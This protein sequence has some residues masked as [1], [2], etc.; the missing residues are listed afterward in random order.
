MSSFCQGLS[1]LV[2]RFCSPVATQRGPQH[3]PALGEGDRVVVERGRPDRGDPREH[4]RRD[5][6]ADYFESPDP[7]RGA[8]PPR[9]V[10]GVDREFISFHLERGEP[11]R[12]MNREQSLRGLVQVFRSAGFPRAESLAVNAAFAFQWANQ[13]SGG[14]TGLTVEGA[15][16]FIDC[17]TDEQ[18]AG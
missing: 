7:G 15:R 11:V 12:A 2:D 18:N 17:L 1:A 4:G 9:Q 13:D 6:R 5:R 3:R 8:G 16:L 14:G 10:R